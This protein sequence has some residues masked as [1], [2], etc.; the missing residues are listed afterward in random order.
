MSGD[1]TDPTVWARR[2]ALLLIAGLVLALAGAVW[3]VRFVGHVGDFLVTR[4][5]GVHGVLVFDECEIA[6]PAECRGV[7]R[8]DDGSERAGITIEVGHIPGPA[9]EVIPAHLQRGS[10]YGYGTDVSIGLHIVLLTIRLVVLGA[11]IWVTWVGGARLR[12]RRRAS[13]LNRG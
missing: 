2:P 5:S 8:A 12:N 4:Y 9:A 13:G 10:G 1:S 11:G 6:P 3:T 7:F